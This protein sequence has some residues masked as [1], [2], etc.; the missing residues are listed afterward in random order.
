MTFF[1]S[2]FALALLIISSPALATAEQCRAIDARKDRHACY[3]RQ[4]TAAEIARKATAESK[5]VGSVEQIK[6]EDD[7]LSRRLRSICKGC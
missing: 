5:A 7:K 2:L 6:I 1:R 3:D 4:T